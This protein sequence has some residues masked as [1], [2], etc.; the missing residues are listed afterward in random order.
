MIRIM[1]LYCKNLFCYCITFYFSDYY[2]KFFGVVHKWMVTIPCKLI[3][4]PRRACA[5]RVIVVV[6]SFCLSVCLSVTT[7]TAATRNKT[8]CQ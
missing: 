3:I 1:L 6:L 4:N 7:F 8:A 5:A 2:E